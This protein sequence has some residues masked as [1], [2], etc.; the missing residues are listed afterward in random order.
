[1]SASRTLILMR[2]AEAGGAYNDHERPLT[3]AG[4][5]DATA[6]GTWIRS[7]LPGVDAVLC[8]T[9]LRTRQTLSAT[10][11]GAPT[12]F[13]QELYGG[14]IDDIL[15]QIALTPETAS[16]VLV[17]GHAPGI[18]ATA[19]ELLT[20]AALA[21]AED[22][23]GDDRATGDPG[24]NREHPAVN[25]LRHF[26]AGAVAVLTTAASWAALDEQGADLQTVRHPRR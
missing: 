2:H 23:S 15:S 7:A 1:M 6:A 25:G 3:P 20:V 14:G 13:A 21:R 24:E 12:R 11:V 8:S 10:G 22:G 19:H 18:P 5:I 17:V 16:T 4:V 26:S 9:A